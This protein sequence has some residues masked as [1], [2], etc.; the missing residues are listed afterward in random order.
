MQEMCIHFLFVTSAAWVKTEYFNL[1]SR[2]K[3]EVYL[4]VIE[5]ISCG[6]LGSLTCILAEQRSLD[7]KISKSKISGINSL[8][9][10]MLCVLIITL[11]SKLAKKKVKLFNLL[12]VDF[13]QAWSPSL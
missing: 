7:L 10:G 12:K 8:D 13:H 3:G 11:C 1:H 2:R 5:L 6:R 9:N 4:S